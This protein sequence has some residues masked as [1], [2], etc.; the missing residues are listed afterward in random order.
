MRVPRALHEKLKKMGGGLVSPTEVLEDLVARAEAGL[1]LSPEVV[2]ELR[3]AGSIG[4][5]LDDVVRF[6]LNIWKNG[7]TVEPE[8]AERLLEEASGRETLDDVIDRIY[9]YFMEGTR[10][11]TIRHYTDSR[12]KWSLRKNNLVVKNG[13]IQRKGGNKL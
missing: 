5:T 12:R 9:L 1:H 7:Y 13:R 6:L 4:E 11:G 8:V 3:R 10:S 2:E